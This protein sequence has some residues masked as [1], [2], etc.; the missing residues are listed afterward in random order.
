MNWHFGVIQLLAI[1]IASLYFLVLNADYF[2]TFRDLGFVTLTLFL[3]PVVYAAV[4]FGFAGSISAAIWVVILSLPSLIF[5]LNGVERLVPILQLTILVTMG[6]LIGLR[7][8]QETN[9]RH[10]MEASIVTLTAS[11]RNYRRLFDSIP[12]PNAYTR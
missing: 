6:I 12:V 8:S 3:I 11:E 7:V 9:L 2:V 1:S 5:G 4:I 10:K